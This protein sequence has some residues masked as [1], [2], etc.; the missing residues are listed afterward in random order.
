MVT[1]QS[2]GSSSEASATPYRPLTPG[3][4]VIDRGFESMID[5]KSMLNQRIDTPVGTGHNDRDSDESHEMNPMHLSLPDGASSSAERTGN[6]SGESNATHLTA[7]PTQ[8]DAALLISSRICVVVSMYGHAVVRLSL[9]PFLRL[10][11]WNY[12]PRPNT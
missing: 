12:T 1:E 6:R 11:S 10:S 9:C 4:P 8:T 3:T 2:K 5:H 7:S